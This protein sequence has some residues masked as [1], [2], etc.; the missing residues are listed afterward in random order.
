[1]HRPQERGDIAVLVENLQEG[2]SHVFIDQKTPIHQGQLVADELPQI[3][4]QL[5]PALLGVEKNPHQPAGL[6][7]ENAV[8]GGMN[9]TFFEFKPIHYLLLRL[10]KRRA[11]KFSERRQAA[12]LGQEG[13]SLLQHASDKIDVPRMLIKIAHESL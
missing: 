13:Q 6:V 7:A 1:M 3:R 12:G 11:D 10:S 8:S 4:V 5:Q 2:L 9:L